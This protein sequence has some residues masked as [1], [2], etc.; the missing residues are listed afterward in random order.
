MSHV[1]HTRTY[2]D[3]FAARTRAGELEPFTGVHVPSRD[4]FLSADARELAA[5]AMDVEDA[6]RTAT[7]IRDR[8]ERLAEL[9]RESLA[10]LPEPVDWQHTPL[11][12]GRVDRYQA[13]TEVTVRA[14]E[15]PLPPLP[16]RPRVDGVRVAFIAL[17]VAVVGLLVWIG[18]E[19]VSAVKHAGQVIAGAA[20]GVLGIGLVVLLLLLLGGGAAAKCVG[21][22]CGGCGK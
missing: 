15:E 22:H 3:P 4:G 12:Q 20:P 16:R 6:H 21:L 8:R 19:V 1:D 17:G 2:P 11:H 10:D 5:L 14:V 18:F 7:R 13:P 9:D